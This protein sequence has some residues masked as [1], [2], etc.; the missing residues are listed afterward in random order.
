MTMLVFWVVVG[1]ILHKAAHRHAMDQQIN[2]QKAFLAYINFS[3][4]MKKQPMD[5]SK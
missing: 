1:G 3:G 2:R 5:Q 4:I